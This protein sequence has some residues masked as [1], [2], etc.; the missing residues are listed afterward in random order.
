MGQVVHKL[1]ECAQICKLE[2]GMNHLALR[3]WLMV[4]ITAALAAV[5]IR[6]IWEVTTTTRGRQPGHNNLA[7][8]GNSWHLCSSPLPHYQAQSKKAKKLAR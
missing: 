3:I 1:K 2:V 8:T 5:V 7:H 6:L 4:S